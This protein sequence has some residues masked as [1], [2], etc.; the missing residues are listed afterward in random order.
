MPP[1][2]RRVRVL[3]VEVD[4]T[5]ATFVRFAID[6]RGGIKQTWQPNTMVGCAYPERGE[7]FVDRSATGI[8]THGSD[9]RDASALLGKKVAKAP[10]AT[11]VAR[12]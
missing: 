9:V 1:G 2:E 8:G 12:P 11:C 6:A 3:D 10:D 5:G 7:V 4:A